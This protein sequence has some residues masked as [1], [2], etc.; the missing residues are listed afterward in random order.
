MSCSHFRWTLSRKQRVSVKGI[1]KEMYRRDLFSVA[2]GIT[3]SA[4]ASPGV[5]I[6]QARP[7]PPL[8][9][10]FRGS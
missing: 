4:V 9:G 10:A 6:P 2:L 1:P 3:P 5:L 7:A 8:D